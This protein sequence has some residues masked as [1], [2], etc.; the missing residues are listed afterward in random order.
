MAENRVQEEYPDH[1]QKLINEQGHLLDKDGVN[2]LT[3]QESSVEQ[4]KILVIEPRPKSASTSV[5]KI[6]T[7]QEVPSTSKAADEENEKYIWDDCSIKRL[8]EY[9][10]EHSN[11]FEEGRLTKKAVWEI[12]AIKFNATS[13]EQA[14]TVTWI[15]LK[16]KWQKL[17]SK[18]KQVEDKNRKSGEGTHNFKYMEEME[19]AVG[20]N[21][22]IRP[23]K[24]ISSMD[25]SVEKDKVQKEGKGK[26]PRKRKAN[27]LTESLGEM[28]REREDRYERFE[29]MVK[30]INKERCDLMREFINVFKNSCNK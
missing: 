22:N 9:R 21:P 13:D 8:I 20:D 30:E 28:K 23:A 17:E 29:S 11:K 2:I 6:C 12:I 5:G 24:T 3:E 7:D 19:E 16:S 27:D 4:E 26:Q 10:K 25:L 15:Q 14:K 1:L 18:F